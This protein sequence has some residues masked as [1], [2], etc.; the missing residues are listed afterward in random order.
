MDLSRFHG[1]APALATPFT[2]R[3]ELDLD[4]LEAMLD[5]YLECGVHGISIAG[6]QGEFFALDEAEHT[7]LIERTVKTVAGKVPVVAG[8]GRSNLMETRR[9]LAAAETAGIDMAMFI[10]PYFVQP[11][12]SELE[13]HYVA[14]AGETALPVLLYNNPPRT[15]VNILPNTLGRIMER[16]SNV[17][18]IKDSAGDLTQ[19]IE[20]LLACDRT[21]LLISGRDTLT[22]SMLVNGGH[23]AVSPACNVFPRLLVRMYEHCRAGDLEEARRI[24][25]LLAPLRAAWALG[26]FPVVI[27]EAMA[28]AGRNAGPARAPI[29]PLTPDAR[30]KLKAVVEAILPEE[31]VLK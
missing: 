4:A 7:A 16:A 3:Q 1:M 20:Y 5:T 10:T 18:G 24:S 23:G 21:G 15:S 14:L 28:L 6:S 29:A 26:S 19:S 17:V 27:K 22:V 9:V 2:D 25:D 31:E 8:C 13:K 30:A 12:Q 11:N